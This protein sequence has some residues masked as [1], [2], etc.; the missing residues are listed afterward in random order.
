[1]HFNIK[2]KIGKIEQKRIN[3]G[4]KEYQMAWEH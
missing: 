1:M 3:K 2:N 4:S